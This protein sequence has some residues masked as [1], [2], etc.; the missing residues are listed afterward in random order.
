MRAWESAKDGTAS[1]HDK[2]AKVDRTAIRRVDICYL[3]R[4]P[5]YHIRTPFRALGCQ[6]MRSG[7][8][9]WALIPVPER[10]GF[11]CESLAESKDPYHNGF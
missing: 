7:E 1:Q 9:N 5:R 8:G 3:P 2:T 4:L 6:Q 11:A 10:Q